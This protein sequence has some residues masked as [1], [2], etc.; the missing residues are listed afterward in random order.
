MSSVARKKQDKVLKERAEAA[1][2]T[3][4]PRNHPGDTILSQIKSLKVT[5]H[6]G[7]H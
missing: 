2:L 6:H 5:E 3:D 1:Q 4:A 7:T